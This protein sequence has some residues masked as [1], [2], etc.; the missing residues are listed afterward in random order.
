MYLCKDSR[1]KSSTTQ[2][3]NA[4]TI[5]GHRAFDAVRGRPIV[6]ASDL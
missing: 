5:S 4:A 6:M 3:M 1:P 2:A